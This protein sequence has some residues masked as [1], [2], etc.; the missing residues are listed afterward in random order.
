MKHA[1]SGE[2][3]PYKGYGDRK[4]AA[5]RQFVAY[6]QEPAMPCLI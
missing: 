1:P 2:L 5:Q 6:S 3:Y 4:L